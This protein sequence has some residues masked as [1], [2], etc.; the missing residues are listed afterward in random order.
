MLAKNFINTSLPLLNDRHKVGD[1]LKLTRK[2][3]LQQFP[4]RINGTYGF[5]SHKLIEA[6]KENTPLSRLEYLMQK[7]HL[8]TDDHIW[9]SINTFNEHKTTVLP[10]L[11][12]E[13][14]FVGTVLTKDIFSRLSEF[15]PIN[16]GGAILEIEMAYRNY[17]LSELA[18]IVEGAN[19]KITLLSVFPIEKTSKVK[20]VFSID[21]TDASELIQAL[22][23]HGLHINAW[24]MNRGEIDN[25]KKERYSALMNYINV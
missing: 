2:H 18:N 25:M 12:K 3:R 20:V 5:F 7:V 11:N 15:F 10:V 16:N 13:Q 24:F 23:R 9:K 19:A 6:V 8:L 17:S 4:T 1:A 21:K 22:D 14:T